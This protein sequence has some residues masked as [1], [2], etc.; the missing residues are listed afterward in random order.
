M[1]M[2]WMRREALNEGLM[3][4]L[5]GRHSLAFLEGA[6]VD[7]TRASSEMR[8]VDWLL[9]LFELSLEN[10]YFKYVLTPVSLR[11]F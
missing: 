10:F 3:E 1:V 9:G 7:Q 6:S 5:E 4:F 11:R 8:Q 2:V